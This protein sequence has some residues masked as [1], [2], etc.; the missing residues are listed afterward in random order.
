LKRARLLPAASDEVD[1]ALGWYAREAPHRLAAFA[2]ALDAT[3]LSIG[4]MPE[5]CPIVELLEHGPVVRRGAVRGFPW[6]MFFVEAGTEVVVIAVA[7][8]RRE[9]GYWRDRAPP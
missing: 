3:L 1:R 6:G 2:D 9:P 7:H 8:A 5:S 4:R